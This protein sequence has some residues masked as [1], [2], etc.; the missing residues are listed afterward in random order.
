[1]IDNDYLIK[2]LS[3][4][5]EQSFR[6]LYE[7]YFACVYRTA[8]KYLHSENLAQDVVQ[9]VFTKIWLNRTSLTDIQNLESYLVVMTKNHTFRELKK[10]AFEQHQQQTYLSQLELD[11]NFTEVTL[12]SQ[13][14]DELLLEAVEQLPPQQKT[15]FILG[16][17]Q[18]MS[19]EDIAHHLN[20]SQGTVKNHMVRALKFVRKHLAPHLAS[21]ILL[22]FFSN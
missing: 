8:N 4:G 22:H 15:V 5:C 1:M 17:M 3:N 6:L 21:F 20:L 16:K 19:H 9:E 12:D 10:I 7:R 13:Q 11:T 18:N 2:Q 14:L